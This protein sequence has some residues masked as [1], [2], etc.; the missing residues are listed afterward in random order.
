MRIVVNPLEAY[1]YGFR[2]QRPGCIF[3]PFDKQDAAAVEIVVK[4]GRFKIIHIPDT[5]Q[6]KVKKRQRTVCVFLHER[7]GWA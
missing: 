6:V 3:A 4:T 2:R 7:E 1:A 5:V